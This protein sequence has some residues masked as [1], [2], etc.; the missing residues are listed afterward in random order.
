MSEFCA[1]RLYIELV[2]VVFLIYQICCVASSNAL[3]LKGT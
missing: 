2:R 3:L 1:K